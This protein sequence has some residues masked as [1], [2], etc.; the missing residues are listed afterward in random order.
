MKSRPVGGDLFH[1]EG[2]TDKIKLII[3]FRSAANALIN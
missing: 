3:A 1:A 2:Q